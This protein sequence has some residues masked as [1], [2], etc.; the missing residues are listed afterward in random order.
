[1]GY[2]RYRY[3][4]PLN[5]KLGLYS[6]SPLLNMGRVEYVLPIHYYLFIPHINI[7]MYVYFYGEPIT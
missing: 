5:N 7:I 4:G 3:L 6:L 2:F 1:M